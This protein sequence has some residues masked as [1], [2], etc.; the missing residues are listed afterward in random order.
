MPDSINADTVDSGLDAIPRITPE[1][2]DIDSRRGRRS[3]IPR[4]DAR[5]VTKRTD[6]SQSFLHG[7]TTLGVF[8]LSFVVLLAGVVYLFLQLQQT[9]ESLIAATVRVEQLEGR[10]VTTDTSLTKSEVLLAAK[11]KSMD[12]LIDGNKLEIHKLWGSSEKNTKSIQS[13]GSDLQQ[14]KQ[15]LQS[16][17]ELLQQTAAQVATDNTLLK[18]VDNTV[19]ETAQRMEIAQENLGNLNA[20]TKALK[21]RQ[22]HLEGDLGKRVVTLEDTAKSTD[23]FRR[24]TLDELRKLKEEI[25][26][27]QSVTAAKP[28]P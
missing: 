20:D 15:L 27:A 28:A 21:D 23:V 1:R 6:A 3:F 18:N 9:R 10:L 22:S 12:V 16:T 19:K 17:S 13:Q 2:E 24:N 26:K 14:Q 7:S 8:I 11:L 25:S 5:A 4:N